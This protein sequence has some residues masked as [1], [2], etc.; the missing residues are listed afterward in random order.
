MVFYSLLP[1]IFH[2]VASLITGFTRESSWLEKSE[3]HRT[4]CALLTTYYYTTYYYTTTTTHYLLT[5]CLAATHSYGALHFPVFQRVTLVSG[6]N[7]AA[8]LQFGCL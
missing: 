8:H 1:V 3:V 7:R 4:Y 5:S 6:G 2:G